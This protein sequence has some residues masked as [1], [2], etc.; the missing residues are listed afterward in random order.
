MADKKLLTLLNKALAMEYQ[1]VIQYQTHASLID[2]LESEPV[3]ARLKELAGDEE[4]H[5]DMLRGRISAL[6][7]TPETKPEKVKVSDKINPV[8]KINLGAERD[9]I[10]IYKKILPM[11]KGNPKLEHEIRHILMD[12]QEHVEEIS[13]LLG[14]AV[15]Y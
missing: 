2:G 8:L 1:A 7:G 15:K 6:G 4:K 9:A 14:V 3:V 11:C 12:E 13:Q 5:A 10:A